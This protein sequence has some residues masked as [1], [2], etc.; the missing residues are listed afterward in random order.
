MARVDLAVLVAI[1]LQVV[2]PDS[3]I[4]GLGNPRSYRPRGALLMAFLIVSP[5]RIGKR[6]HAYGW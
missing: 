5:G 4:R 3:L 6:S 2:L 1:A